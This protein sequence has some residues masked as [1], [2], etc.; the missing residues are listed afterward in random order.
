[1]INRIINLLLAGLFLFA[2]GT[3]AEKENESNKPFVVTT[4]GMLY[5][6][7]RN[8]AGDKVEAI[9]LMG[10]GVDPH[11]YKATQGDLVKINKADLVIY[12]GL[13][14][15]G[16]MGEILEKVAKRK[17]VLAAAES[18]PKGQLISSSQFSHSYDPH[19]WFDVSLWQR[20]VTSVAR[21]LQ[22]LDTTNALFYQ[23]RL[24]TYSEELQLL[25][26]EVIRAINEIPEKQ[27]T[28]VTAHDAF[29][30]FGRAYQMEVEGLQGLSTAS[31]Y[32][33][34][35]IALI[36]DLIIDRDLRAIFVETSVSEKAIKAVLDG[37]QEKGHQVK[38]GGALYS[39]AMGAFDTKEGTY[40]GMVRSNVKTIVSGLK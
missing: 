6:A 39:D 12:N 27:R 21:E 28:L 22:K 14:L 38:I 20:V 17:P 15:E 4:T 40:A 3:T 19:V 26:H 34:K 31:D 13:F 5:D 32:G 36:T 11:L 24:E 2:C 30:Y 9:A 10:P 18:L 16:K 33:L 25:H 1:M 23:E 7:V 29:G 37:C 8:I 35:D